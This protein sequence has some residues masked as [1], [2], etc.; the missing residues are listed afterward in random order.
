MALNG[1]QTS[2]FDVSATIVQ[3]IGLYA[4]SFSFKSAGLYVYARLP[5]YNPH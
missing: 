4:Y 2:G 3:N 5:C 1:A